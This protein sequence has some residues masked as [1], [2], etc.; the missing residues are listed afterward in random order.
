[1]NEAAIRRDE[2]TPSQVM[3]FLDRYVIGQSKAKKAVAVALRN[4]IRRKRLPE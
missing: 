4:R 1:M 2:L 3:A